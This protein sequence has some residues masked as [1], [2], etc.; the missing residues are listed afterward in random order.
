M[1]FENPRPEEIAS[2]LR[3][4]RRVAVVGVSAKP[5]RDSH[6]V[7]R[8]LMEQGYE[9]LPV[10]PHETEILGKAVC[11]DIRQIEG[12]LDIVDV[13]RRSQATDEIIDAAIAVQAGAIWLQ[14]GIHNETGLERA[15]A[16]GLAAVQNKCIAK[17]LRQLKGDL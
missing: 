3:A 16:A 13:F 8:F 5:D 6:K 12:H 2:L 1:A 14:E 7:A 17:Q 15:R 9:V 11:S 4:A 10:N